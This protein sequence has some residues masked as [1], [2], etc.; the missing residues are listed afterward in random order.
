MAMDATDADA[1]ADADATPT[2]DANGRRRLA[3]IR[4]GLQMD[5]DATPMLTPTLTRRTKPM[6]KMDFMI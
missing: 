3:P 4:I 1:D 2:R 5:A 6:D